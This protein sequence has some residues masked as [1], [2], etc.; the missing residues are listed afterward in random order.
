MPTIRRKAREYC[1]D[2]LETGSP[3]EVARRH[4]APVGSVQRV[5]S[6]QASRD[7]IDGVRSQARVDVRV[8]SRNERL[9]ILSGIARGA[10]GE[11]PTDR[12]GACRLIAHMQ[13]ELHTKATVE[14]TRGIDFASMPIAQVIRIARGDITALPDPA[15]YDDANE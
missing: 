11:C 12:I 5:L 10:S 1:D 14:V 2:Y 7:Y 8:A 9:A 4:D 15:E 13:G 6:S 3:S